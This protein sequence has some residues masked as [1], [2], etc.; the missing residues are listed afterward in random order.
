MAGKPGTTGLS[1]L[2]PDDEADW[3]PEK[4]YSPNIFLA[5]R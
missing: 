1:A 2:D 3:K 4:R 5:H